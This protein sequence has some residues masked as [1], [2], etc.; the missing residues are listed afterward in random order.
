MKQTMIRKLSLLIIVTIVFCIS[1]CVKDTYDMNKLSKKAHLSPT[2]AISA[3]KGDISLSDI[4]KSG[5]T[6]V[7]DQNKF[8]KIVFKKDSIID[9]KLND[10]YDLNNMVSFSQ[11]YTIGEL[12]INPFQSTI[13]YTLDQISQR[14]STAL[15]NQFVALN[16]G[17]T[18][19]FPPFPS[20]NLGEQTFSAPANFQNAVFASGFLDISIKNNLTAPLN[21]ISVSLFNTTGHAAIGS[22]V[23]IPPIQP[24]QTQT[25]S[26][27]LTNK[28]LTNSIIAA[29]VL[30]GSPGTSTP[31][32]ISLTNSNIQISIQGRNLKV[33]SG[34]VIIPAQTITTLDNKDTISFDPG[35]G[36]ELVK[37]KINTGNVS[38][39]IQSVTSLNSSLTLTMPTAIR[40]SSTLTEVINIAPSSQFDGNISVNNTTVDLNTDVQQPYNRIP[41][42]YA[43]N[44]NSNNTLT[45]F[46]STD[47]VMLTLK[48]LNPGF[49][50]VKGYFGQ[51]VKSIATESV[52]LNIKDILSH[53][54]GD[55]SI[56]SPS[57]KLNYSNSFAIPI[58]VTLLGTGIKGTRT[59]NLNYAPFNIA[60]PVALA[61]RDTSAS[62][63]IDK[64]NS[65]LSQ[66]ISMPPE[67]ISFSG[68]A[69]MN[70]G[71]NNGLRNNYV[72]GNSRF[73][74]SVEVEMPLE[75]K[76]NNIQFT[77]TVDNFLKSDNNDDNP[78][79]P[80]DFKLLRIDINAKNGFPLGASLKMS[81]YDSVNHVI[82]N[83]VDATGILK[84]APVDSNGKV[85]GVTD[86][87]TSIEFTNSFFSSIDK[88]DKIIFSFT[89][90]TTDNGT[91]DVKIYSDYR[92]SFN[93]ALVV[94]PD[95]NLK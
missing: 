90:V 2:L 63:I 20:T 83:T 8:V 50:Y 52:D 84:P 81:L 31:V 16:D 30:S 75:L 66:I 53:I 82:R 11:S 19:L 61:R 78:V 4:V 45:T 47:K 87:S 26:I 24:G 41:L 22:A 91:R 15:R 18:H 86:S 95:I 69:K 42:I 12:S 72:F 39:H 65:S 7:F 55:L 29:T 36:I 14:F 51:Q 88:A 1:G 62:L 43:L 64:N 89:L 49:D 25:A 77:D 28:T 38:Y 44:V 67:E 27:D 3:I 60:I 92:I 58:E 93:A 21:S 68:S 73:L 10:F 32:I 9:L 40:N 80:E 33:K 57:I 59:V 94:K 17:A 13:V 23:T 46:N 5:D 74:G 37:L 85:T 71:V 76:L 34:R 54:T 6:V 35:S 56:T 70:P 48:L 79:K